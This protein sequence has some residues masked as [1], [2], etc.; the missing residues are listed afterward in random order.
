MNLGSAG[1]GTLAHL[2]ADAF[3]R[4]ASLGGTHIPY[5]GST[6]ALTDVMG[7]QIEGV[8]DTPSGVLPSIRSDK[9]RPLAIAAPKRSSQ[10][11]NVPTLAEVGYPELDFR[12]WMGLLT[13]TGTPDAVVRRIESS[14]AEVMRDP[15]FRAALTAQGWDVVGSRSKEFASFLDAEIPTLAA[16][17]RAAGVKAGD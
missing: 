14:I 6:P 17:A 1:P 10:L 16:A 13:R 9:V 7:G 11:P 15:A 2:A 3:N 5:K 4:R 8:F 12:T